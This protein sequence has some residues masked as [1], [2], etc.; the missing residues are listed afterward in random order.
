MAVLNVAT[1]TSIRSRIPSIAAADLSASSVRWIL[2][3]VTVIIFL[4]ATVIGV[5]LAT[6][7]PTDS[8]V[9]TSGSSR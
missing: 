3:L 8:P 7:A 9:S 2:R 6:A 5:Q 4:V 1:F